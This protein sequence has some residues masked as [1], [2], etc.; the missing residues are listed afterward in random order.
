[1]THITRPPITRDLDIEALMDAVRW[2]GAETRAAVILAGQLLAARRYQ[3]GYDYFLER[4]GAAPGQPLFLALAGFFQGRLGRH[5]DEA[6]AKLDDA[7][8]RELGLP[9]YFRGLLLADLP[10][11]AGRA[12][13]AAADLELVLA[14]RDQFPVGFLRGVRRALAEAYTALDR[15][16]EAKAALQESGYAHAADDV[17]LLTADYWVTAEEGFHFVPPRLMEPVPGVYVA[18]GFDFSDFA[19]VDT[20]EGIVAIDTGS[21]PSHA[22]NALAELR[23]ITD[24]PITHVILTHAH[25]DHVGGLAAVTDSGAEVIAQADF[26]EEL[27]VQDSVTVPWPYFFPAEGPQRQDV[28]PDRLVKGIETLT[29]GGVD[30]V[31][32]PV[33]GGETRDGLVIH[34]PDRGVLFTGDMIMPYLGAPFLP[35]GSPG[36][37]FDAMRLVRELE[38]RLLIHGHP[39]LTD[40]FT[41]EIFAGL[42]AALRDLYRVVV[43][44]IRE[45]ETVAPILHR[46]HLPGVLRDHPGA[47]VPYLVVRDNFVNRVYHQ[48][49][50]YWKADGE[51]VERFAPTEWAAALDLLGG[52]T[53]D[54]FASAGQDLLDR[55]DHAIALQL[56]DYGRLRYPDSGRLDGIRRQILYR[57][58]ERHQQLDPFK[59]V[60]YAGMA[61]LE[62]PVAR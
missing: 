32:H 53:E 21:S 52:G 16:D 7:A 25:W 35:E 22:T 57:L 18:Q 17:P 12:E 29:V 41:I 1:M 14:V 19:F 2:P 40:V 51:G 28:K 54:A 60:I 49:T 46:N 55:G 11:L 5:L 50:G 9:N 10:G 26:A 20:G 24:R 13:T 38:P 30:F 59:F 36:G 27:A 8:A 45:G 61:G 37:L 23:K 42:E 31:L 34:L 3:E 62:L 43:R 44:A 47:V 56:V 15:H 4:A 33:H 58:V 39:P 6:L 48:N